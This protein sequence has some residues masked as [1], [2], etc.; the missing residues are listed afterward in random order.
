MRALLLC[1]ALSSFA[2]CA[3]PQAP[4]E[5]PASPA[6]TAA[7]APDSPAKPAAP[8][9]TGHGAATNFRIEDGKL[10]LPGPV[11][12]ETGSDRLKPESDETLSFVKDYLD[13]K[14]SITTLRVEGHVYG[15]PEKENQALSEK[16]TLAA[17]RWLIGKGISCQRLLPVG[18]GSNKPAAA[19]GPPR[20]EFANAALRNRPIGGLPVDGGGH[21]AGDPCR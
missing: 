6:S 21:P 14:D 9:A 7:P 18:F 11:L 8:A 2:A 12:F 19:G 1:L 3:A 15:G 17:T 13:A 5:A 16:R 10:V 20:L 4:P